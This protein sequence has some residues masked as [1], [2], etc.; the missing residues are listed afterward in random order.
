VTL[1]ARCREGLT[2]STLNPCPKNEG[3]PCISM[4]VGVASM[5]GI[6]HI[7]KCVYFYLEEKE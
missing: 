2:P 6:V 7:E 1:Y 4:D 5:I 3:K